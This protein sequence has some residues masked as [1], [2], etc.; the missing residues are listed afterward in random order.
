MKGHGWLVLAVWMGTAAVSFGAQ[1]PVKIVV[2]N[3]AGLGSGDLDAA[4]TAGRR[5]FQRLGVET[6]WSVCR[7]YEDCNFPQDGRYVRMSVLPHATGKVMGFAN[8]DSAAAGRP[9][10]YAYDGPVSRLAKRTGNPV[11][12]ALS[13]VM[14]HEILHLLG[15][16][17]APHGLMR[18]I[19]DG[20]D[21][22]NATHGPALLPD[23]VRQLRSGLAQFQTRQLAAAR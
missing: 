11:S 5:L 16:E 8:T 18:A 17:H 2:L 4:I 19:L 9:Q 20:P 7:R 14:V 22:A 10:A 21:L 1:D 13:C 3:S 6:I 12:L 15:L 23:Q